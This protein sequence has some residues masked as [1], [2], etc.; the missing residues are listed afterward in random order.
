M[1]PI[2]QQVKH[3][4]GSSPHQETESV[5]KERADHRWVEREPEDALNTVP[6]SAETNPEAGVVT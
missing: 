3:R 2:H 6:I 1:D 4:R 5:P